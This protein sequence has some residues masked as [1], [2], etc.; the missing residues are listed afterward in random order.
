MTG[1]DGQSKLDHLR[2]TREATYARGQAE[3]RNARRER[4]GRVGTPPGA[5]A[6][7]GHLQAALAS[8]RA[9]ASAVDDRWRA[10]IQ[11]QAERTDT[12]LAHVHRRD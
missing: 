6:R 8:L 1:A 3:A 2:A 7:V 4:Q 12:L 9:A 5:Q 11:A 10:K